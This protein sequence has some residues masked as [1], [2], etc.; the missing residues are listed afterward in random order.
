[1]N[2]LQRTEDLTALGSGVAETTFTVERDHD[3]PV[4]PAVGQSIR[5]AVE[6]LLRNHGLESLQVIP[7][8][9]HDGA[10][11]LY[12][13]L[14]FALVGSRGR[15]DFQDDQRLLATKTAC[16]SLAWCLPPCLDRLALS[17]QAFQLE[18]APRAASEARVRSAALPP[19]MTA[20]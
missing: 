9:D 17:R 20:P 8:L 12:V 7:G 16:V 6:P 5:N 4:T 2:F 15:Y 13:D 10:P 18:R 1:V 3:H 11:V 19:R 14:K